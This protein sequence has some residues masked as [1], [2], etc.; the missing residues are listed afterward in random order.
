MPPVLRRQHNAQQVFRNSFKDEWNADWVANIDENWIA[1]R[2]VKICGKY[3]ARWESRY[4]RFWL[5]KL[6]KPRE[7]SHEQ[8]WLNEKG[9]LISLRGVANLTMFSQSGLA[10]IDM[11][12][13]HEETHIGI[14]RRKRFLVYATNPHL[15][16]S[17]LFR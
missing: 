3:P 6:D 15:M 14:M 12:S 10:T 7:Y 16:N 13:T 8:K 11:D 1:Y 2:R 9:W 4:I 5:S 17:T